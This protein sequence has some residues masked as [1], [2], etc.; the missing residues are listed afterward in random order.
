MDDIRE[1]ARAYAKGE[2]VENAIGGWEDG[3]EAFLKGA[4]VMADLAFQWI[5]THADDY[6]SIADKRVHFCDHQTMAYD[7]VDILKEK[8]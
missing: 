4:E 1:I 3:E 5:M 6:Y 2:W 8:L 7:M